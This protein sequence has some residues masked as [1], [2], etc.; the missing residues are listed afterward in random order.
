MVWV[1]SPKF[2]CDFSETLTGVDN[3][4]FDMY[5]PVP[6]YGVISDLPSTERVP[7]HTCRSLTHIYCYMDYGISAVQGRP[8]QQH[9]VF[10]GTVCSH[11]WLLLS[12]PVDSKELVRV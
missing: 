5:L 4:L 7:P 12:L 1:D 2:F 9:Q 10:D 6:A 3:S 11:K 8:K